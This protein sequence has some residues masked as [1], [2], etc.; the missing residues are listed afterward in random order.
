MGW[1]RGDKDHQIQFVALPVDWH[2]LRTM[3]IK[4]TEGHDFTE[5]DGDC[6]IINE[7]ARKKWD[8]VEMDKK[9]LEDDL[10]VI[11][12]CQNLR[13]ASTRVDNNDSPMAF[14]VYGPIYKELGWTNNLGVMNVRVAEGVDK[15]QMRKTIKDICMKLGAK[16]EPEVKFLDQMLEQT[17]QEEFRFVRQV[18]IFSLICLVITLI[19]VFCMTMFETEYRR[20][21]IG[22]RK[23]MGS[24]TQE[25]LMMFCRHYALLLAISFIIAAP[26]AYYIGQQWLQSFAERTPIYW[27]LFPLALLTVGVITLTTVIIQ[28][29]RT[30]NENPVNSI[31][32]E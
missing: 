3:G 1:G 22:I 8:W 18:F 21:E 27:W 14:I 31:K 19:G 23:V 15:V 6:Y 16:H 24:S 29:W 17:Y 10:P 5:H 26:V 11:G 20:K 13:F 12:V 32:N 28:S 2:Y 7:A 30:A 4:V 9:L 25:I